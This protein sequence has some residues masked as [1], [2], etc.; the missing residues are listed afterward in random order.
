VASKKLPGVLSLALAA[1]GLVALAPATIGAPRSQVLPT[2]GDVAA[3]AGAVGVP[4][5][6]T[7]GA[8]PAGGT[9][10][11][12][13]PPRNGAI[14]DHVPTDPIVQYV[15]APGFQGTDTFWY[16]VRFA[17]KQSALALVTTNVTAAPATPP[18]PILFADG[19]ESGSLTPFE[20]R[21][22]PGRWDTI[23]ESPGTRIRVAG[24]QGQDSRFALRAIDTSRRNASAWVMGSFSPVPQATLRADLRIDR[25]RLSRNELRSLMRIGTGHP[26]RR[27]EVG[28]WRT[29]RGQLRWM[30]TAED[31][32]SR[33]RFTVG[34]GGVPLRR[35]VPIELRTEFGSGAGRAELFVD[36]TL[37]LSVKGVDLAGALAR[38]VEL[39]LLYTELP[40]DNA[41]V[42][43][44]NVLVT[45][46]GI[47]DA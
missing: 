24:G 45:A 17:D 35:Y 5:V 6:I 38:R 29:S 21:T 25:L 22:P 33:F 19:F 46:E 43:A 23:A 39:G 4:Q 14:Q 32:R 36:G 44:D 10:E 15:P 13:V 41:T 18:A 30:A 47:P 3:P 9:Y 27:F 20:P 8:A 31:R 1:L 37:R 28:V 12:A 16:R 26:G 34:K 2:P 42:S 40:R 7:L 11:V